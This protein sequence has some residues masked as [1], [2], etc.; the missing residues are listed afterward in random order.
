MRIH[1]YEL[2]YAPTPTHT[3]KILDKFLGVV[4]DTQDTTVKEHK[5]V[6]LLCGRK[7]KKWGRR[8]EGKEGKI[9][10]LIKECKSV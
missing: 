7:E 2:L 4:M 1:R 9:E 5:V 6:A 8:G 10:K 3:T